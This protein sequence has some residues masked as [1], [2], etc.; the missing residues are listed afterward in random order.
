MSLIRK[1]RPTREPEYRDWLRRQRCCACDAPPPCDPSHHG[2]HGVGTKPPDWKAIPL[3]VE[4]HR[5]RWHRSGA[6]PGVPTAQSER[7]AWCMRQARA[8]RKRYHAWRRLMGL[9][10]ARAT[11]T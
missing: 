4:C 8:H 5:N 11:F 9:A 3:C 2:E 10:R 7:R 6:I 1:H